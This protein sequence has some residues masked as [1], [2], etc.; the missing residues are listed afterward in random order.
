VQA[1]L[2][3]VFFAVIFL[4]AYAG[5]VCV[6]LIGIARKMGYSGAVGVFAVVPG[7]NLLLAWVLAIR[8]WPIERELQ[9]LRSGHRP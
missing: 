5:I 9:R 4:I 3:T 8:A 1:E 2:G 7:V 6:P